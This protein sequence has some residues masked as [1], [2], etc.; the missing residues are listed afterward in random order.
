MPPR[1]DSYG[2]AAFHGAGQDVSVVVVSVLPDQVD[3]A[4][5]AND[6]LRLLPEA[7]FV[8]C[9]GPLLY[10]SQVTSL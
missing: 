2:D 5:R 3:P 9:D 4:R 1:P 6:F 7:F 10:L 8:G